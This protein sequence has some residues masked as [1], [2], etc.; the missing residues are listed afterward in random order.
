MTMPTWADPCYMGH[1]IGKP[2]FRYPCS[3]ANCH[4]PLSVYHGLHRCMGSLITS[5]MTSP[6]PLCT[7]CGPSLE[8]C[9]PSR[10]PMLF[11]LRYSFSHNLS[12]PLTLTCLC[13]G[14]KVAVRLSPSQLLGWASTSAALERQETRRKLPQLCLFQDM[15]S[16]VRNFSTNSTIY[17]L[18][19]LL[20][21]QK[22]AVLWLHH[23]SSYQ[24]SSLRYSR[25]RR[26]WKMC[27][28]PL[29]ARRYVWCSNCGTCSHC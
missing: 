26:T 16:N 15:P 9:S 10:S 1:S 21:P 29:T 28:P 11:A 18:A 6:R 12:L 24:M 7:L 14:I 3:M 4:I 2:H 23:P 17:S 8:A 20:S 13:L 5:R 25:S 22:A 27:Y 19:H